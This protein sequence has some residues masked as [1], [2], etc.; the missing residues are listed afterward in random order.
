[1]IASTTFTIIF[2]LAIIFIADKTTA[3]DLATAKNKT[4]PKSL[5]DSTLVENQNSAPVSFLYFS[6]SPR[7]LIGHKWVHLLPKI[8]YFIMSYSPPYF[9]FQKITIS[10]YYGSLCADCR[11]LFANQIA[12]NLEK[13]KKYVNFDFVPY[14]NVEVSVHIK[15]I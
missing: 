3:T 14:G 7:T 2:L 6:H 13:F 12:Q 11:N 10:V 4:L 8:S 9:L 5:Q 15:Y 1:M